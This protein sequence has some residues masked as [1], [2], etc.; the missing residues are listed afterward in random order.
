MGENSSKS[1]VDAV[2][3]NF[4]DFCQFSAKN[5]VF[6]KNLVMMNFFS[7]TSKYVV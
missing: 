2:I 4:Y 3:N 5:G 6:L 7:K 1:G